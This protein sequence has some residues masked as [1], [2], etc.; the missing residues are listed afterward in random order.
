MTK[1]LA[2]LLSLVFT[3]SIRA[4]IPPAENLLPSDTLFVLTVPDCMA[5]RA[6]AG[7]SP[8]WL[9]WNDPAMDAFR[10]KFMARFNESFVTPLEQNLGLKLADYEDLPQG[11]LTVAVTQNGWTGGDNTRQPGVL[12]LLDAGNKSDLLKT[13]LA[14]LLK[15]W[16]EGGKPIHT[17]DIRGIPFSVLPMPRNDLSAALSGLVPGLQLAQRT[18]AT[19]KSGTTRRTGGRPV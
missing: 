3:V 10:K 13:N 14:A 1:S 7:R 8:S 5:L 15:K 9:F 16:T 6:A 19:A 2:I 11:Q 17:A 12:L 18:G 4:A